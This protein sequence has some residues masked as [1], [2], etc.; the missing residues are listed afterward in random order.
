MA[1]ISRAL[2]RIKSDP[3]AKL[4]GAEAVNE[5]FRKQ[6]H[7]WRECALDPAA[8]MGLFVRQILN[9]NVAISALPH[10]VGRKV[11][12]S[13]YCEARARLPLNGVAAL[14]EKVSCDCIKTIRSFTEGAGSPFAGRRRVHL[15]DATTLTLP[16]EPALQDLWPQPA[17]QKP[18]CGFPM[19]KLLGLLDLATGL[20]LHATLTCLNCHEM[21][22]LAGLHAR[23][24]PGDVLLADRAFC[25]FSHLFYLLKLRVDG[26]FRLHQRQIADFTPGR[27]ARKKGRRKYRRDVPSSRFV[28]ALGRE[29]QLVEWIKPRNRPA[30]MTGAQFA[31]LPA[32]LLVRELRYRIVE[33]G[34]RTR[35]VTIATTLLDATRYPKARIA[36]LYGL[37]WEIETCFRHM[38]QTMK[39]DQLKCK[40]PDG[41]TK[42]LLVYLM[43]Y[44]LV[45]SAMVLAAQ[46]QDVPPGR[47]SFVDAL[48]WLCHGGGGDDDGWTPALIVNPLRPGRWC[49]RVKKRRMKEYDL[50]M[51]PRETYKEPSEGEGVED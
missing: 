20:I 26:V 36:K 49:P 15:A 43:V 16:D 10:L 6:G 19:M 38:K 4:G 34:R 33:R 48:R 46:R 51:R 23:L 27:K 30:W 7:A 13:S 31:A 40:T 39:M 35:V 14:V 21:S 50:M 11:A 41:V 9:G 24:S 44:N 5:H 32:T 2:S 8:T 47:I 18:G 3:L 45:R 37:R 1:I 29:D 25:S 22:Q 42:E 12:E 28:R 17:A